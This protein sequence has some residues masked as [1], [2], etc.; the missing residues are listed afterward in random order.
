MKL[1]FIQGVSR[2]KIDN[3]DNIYT[4]ANFNQS[5]WNRYISYCDEL[6]VILRR[7]EAVYDVAEAMRRFNTFDTKKAKHI[8][9]KDVYRPI[10]NIINFA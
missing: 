4:D 3:K 6:T 1:L 5:I 10:K 8:E 9:L 7:E 2:W